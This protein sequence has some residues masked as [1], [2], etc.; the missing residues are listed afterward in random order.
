MYDFEFVFYKVTIIG[1]KVTYLKK[2]DYFKLKTFEG[3]SKI[4]NQTFNLAF[5]TK[6]SQR[7]SN[8]IDNDVVNHSI[9]IFENI[10][11]C[12]Y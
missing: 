3:Q 1:T 5:G 11:S 6:K 8:S 9:N 7:I 12:E 10:S 4:N 2:P